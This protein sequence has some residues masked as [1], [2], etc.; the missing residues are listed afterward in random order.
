MHVIGAPHASRHSISVRYTYISTGGFGEPGNMFT[1]VTYCFSFLL[2][3]IMSEQ[4]ECSEF[5]PAVQVESTAKVTRVTRLQT[6]WL[7]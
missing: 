5:V 7:P 6:T 3:P 1:L 2:P 4:P